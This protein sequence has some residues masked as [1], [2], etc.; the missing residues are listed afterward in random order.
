MVYNKISFV[1]TYYRS[2]QTFAQ[3]ICIKKVYPHSDNVV[4]HYSNFHNSNN[5]VRLSPI[6]LYAAGILLK[7]YRCC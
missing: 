5:N 7:L 2:I 6:I 1:S 3:F 4:S